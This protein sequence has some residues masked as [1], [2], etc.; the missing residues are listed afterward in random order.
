[1][2]RHV[3]EIAGHMNITDYYT[4]HSIDSHAAFSIFQMGMKTL[5]N[6]TEAMLIIRISRAVL[7]RKNNL[8][9]RM[10]FF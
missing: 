4:R 3:Y 6:L 1:M 9:E 2:T 10:S 5:L 7:Q 8:L